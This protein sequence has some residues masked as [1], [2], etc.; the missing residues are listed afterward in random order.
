VKG[1]TFFSSLADF[2]SALQTALQEFN[3]KN[4]DANVKF[5][6]QSQSGTHPDETAVCLTILYE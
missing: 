2:P 4:P 1:Y 6:S 3:Q 5:V